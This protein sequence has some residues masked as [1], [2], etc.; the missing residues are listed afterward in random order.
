[1]IIKSS[2]GMT[3]RE[4]F[5]MPFS[6]PRYTTSAVKHKKISMK[7]TGDTGEVIKSVKYPSWAAAFPAPVR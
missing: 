5:S 1:M 2:P 4:N 6:T 7:T 3:I